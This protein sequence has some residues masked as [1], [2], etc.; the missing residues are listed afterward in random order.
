MDD[1]LLT[2]AGTLGQP[3]GACY[4][5]PGAGFVAEVVAFVVAATEGDEGHDQGQKEG[6]CSEEKTL[7][8]RQREA[9]RRQHGFKN[10]LRPLSRKQTPPISVKPPTVRPR[11][12]R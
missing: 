5:E 4:Q 12:L 11:T 10:T 7:R 9:R 3:S 2:L 8:V 1:Q 6:A